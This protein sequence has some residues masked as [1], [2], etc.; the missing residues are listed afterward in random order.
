MIEIKNL[1]KQK[2]QRKE[3]NQ[4]QATIKWHAWIYNKNSICPNIIDHK[5]TH[6]LM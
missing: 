3:H 4:P 1:H 2:I 6:P 5:E